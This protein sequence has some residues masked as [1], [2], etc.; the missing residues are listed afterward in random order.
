VI[1]FNKIAMLGACKALRF[2]LGAATS[3]G[4][5]PERNGPLSLLPAT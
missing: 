5:H 2:G 4:C 3:W 1:V